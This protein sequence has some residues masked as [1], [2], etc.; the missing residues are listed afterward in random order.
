MDLINVIF[1][2]LGDIMTG[3]VGVISNAFTGVVSLWYTTPSGSNTTGSL[4]LL[5][6][7]SLIAFVF[8]VVWLAIRFI[9]SMIALRQAR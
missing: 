8:G 2:A 9:G 1:T 4:T 5:G 7:L 3:A 6:V